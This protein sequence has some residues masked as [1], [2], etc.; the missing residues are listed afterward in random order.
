MQNKGISGAVHQ[1]NVLYTFV[2]AEKKKVI[3][4]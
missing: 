1:N 2:L 3:N 4:Q